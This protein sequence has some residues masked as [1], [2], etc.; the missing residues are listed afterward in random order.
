MSKAA[1]LIPARWA[2]TRFPGKPLHPIAGKP[3]IQHVWERA[4]RARQ[5]DRV[6]VA[7]DDMRIAETAF[8]F[9]AEVA[10]TAANLPTGTDRIAAVS[11]NL[12]THGILVN[13]QGDEPLVDP[14]L[15]DRLILTLRAHPR[16]GMA[17][18]ASRFQHAAD[19]ASPDN[20]KVV[21]DT[22]GRALYFSR[23]LIPFNRD[24][25]PRA[26]PCLHHMGIYAFRRSF[27]TQFVRWKPT[28][29]EK[30]EKLE[31]LRALENG[32]QILVVE[33]K[34]RSPGVDRPQD[35]A[36]IESIIGTRKPRN[37]H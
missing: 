24:N 22:K 8:A 3:L 35:V 13:V 27:L 32:G 7:T 21:M 34:H 9:G 10:M 37:N 25:S 5:A 36:T 23:S 20:V 1:I 15:I 14:A 17:T 29:L 19:A 31:Q 6:I 26:A 28:P 30:T 4:S 12:K 16:V 2:S 11:A 33:T 18:A